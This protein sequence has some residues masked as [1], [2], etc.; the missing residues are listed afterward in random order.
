MSS[1]QRRPGQKRLRAGHACPSVDPDPDFWEAR[2]WITGV[3]S[4][5]GGIIFVATYFIEGRAAGH[6]LRDVGAVALVLGS[7]AIVWLFTRFRKAT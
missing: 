2:W 7:L 1:R 6:V 5:V 4:V 3:V